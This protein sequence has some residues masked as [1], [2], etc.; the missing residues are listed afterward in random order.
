MS[1]TSENTAILLSRLIAAGTAL[2]AHFGG[3]APLAAL[4]GRPAAQATASAALGLAAPAGHRGLA[5]D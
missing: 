2:A 4:L 1:P 3:S 5:A